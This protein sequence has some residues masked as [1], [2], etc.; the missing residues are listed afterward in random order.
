MFWRLGTVGPTMWIGQQ[1]PLPSAFLF[2]LLLGYPYSHDFS[3]R[4]SLPHRFFTFQT[5]SSA[6]DIIGAVVEGF[7]P[8]YGI[9]C[10]CVGLSRIPTPL[11]RCLSV[12]S[13]RGIGNTVHK[14]PRSSTI[15]NQCGIAVDTRTVCIIDVCTMYA[16]ERST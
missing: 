4:R 6:G 14:V 10:T 9:P 3:S 5:A 13:A 1:D 16:I 8:G 2:N 12:V 7:L 15:T 11:L